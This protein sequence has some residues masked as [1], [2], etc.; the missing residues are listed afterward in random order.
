[1]KS[2]ID[3]II[4]KDILPKSNLKEEVNSF[5]AIFGFKFIAEVIKPKLY[6]NTIDG[7]YEIL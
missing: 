1:M 2:E 4:I 5:D 6:G 3:G 7:E